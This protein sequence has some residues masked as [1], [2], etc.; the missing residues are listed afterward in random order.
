MYNKLKCFSTGLKYN[1]ARINL[2]IMK[3]SFFILFIVIILINSVSAQELYKM[4]NHLWK[5]QKDEVYRFDGKKFIS[6]KPTGGYYSSN[7]TMVMEDGTQL[8]ADPVQ[9]GPIAEIESYSGT[10]YVLRPGK[11]VL[12]DGLVVNEDFTCRGFLPSKNTGNS[13]GDSQCK[14]KNYPV[15]AGGKWFCEKRDDPEK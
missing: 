15:L 9:L 10:L 1:Y 13:F 8:H 7:M 6:T 5:P 14:T 2:Y 12:F 11:L 3:A 4:E